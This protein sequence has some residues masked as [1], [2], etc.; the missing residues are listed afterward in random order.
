[1]EILI[2][3]YAAIY[4]G[5]SLIERHFTILPKDKTKDGKVSINPSDIKDLFKFYRLAKIN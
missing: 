2:A 4:N 5:A 1:M 3:S